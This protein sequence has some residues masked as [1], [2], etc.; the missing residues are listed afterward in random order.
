MSNTRDKEKSRLFNRRALLLGSGQAALMSVLAGRLYYLQV[1][2][3]DEYTMMADENRM[4]IRLLAPLRGRILDRTGQEIASNRQNFRVVLVREQTENVE[5][6]LDRLSDLVEVSEDDRLKVLKETRRKR[7]FVPIPVMENLT[8]EEFSRINVHSPELPGIHLEV[9]E[10]RH[11]PYNHL[12]S[13]TVG[14]VG[15]VSERDLRNLEPDPLLELPGFRIGKSGIEKFYD[16]KLR[17]TAGTSRVEANAYGRVIRELSRQEGEP[18]EDLELTIDVRLQDYAVE[19]MGEESAAAVVLDIHSG[20]ILSMVSVPSFNPNSFTT[21]I[22]VKEWEGLRSNPKNPLSNK[23]ITGQY[24]PGS[25]F[26]MVVA[27]AALE[28]GVISPDYKVFCGGHTMLGKHKFHCWKR[29]GHG[30]LNLAESIAQSCD[31]YFYDIA[32]KVGIDK[33][34]EMA[35]HFGLGEK[36]DLDLYGEKRGLIPTTSWKQAVRG[37]RWQVGDTFNAGIGQGYVLTTPLQLAVM[38]ARLANGGKKVLPRLVRHQAPIQND[39]EKAVAVQEAEEIGLS[40]SALQHVLRGMFEVVND[41]KGTAFGA[42]ID[43]DG[44]EMAGK[45]GTAQVRRISKKERLTGVLKAEERPWEERDHA[46]F[47]AYAPY[48]NPKYA[49]SVIVEHGGSASKVAAPMARD[50]LME[51]MKLDPIAQTRENDAEKDSSAVRGRD[52]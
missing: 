37:E 19:R 36:L 23:A 2:Q 41:K 35:N 10:K 15:A 25:T 26:K 20:D 4:N 27:L 22:S 9:G 44:R 14:Y 34:A 28:A 5:K 49:V 29:G 42:R 13:H 18:G 51:A 31:V 47:V 16:M 38:T 40:K 52:A 1:M 50:L 8:W 48:D 7:G 11:Y 45:S 24:P 43:E 3:S 17:G 30:K 32:R 46:L 39:G 33:I 21:G 6:T 12:F